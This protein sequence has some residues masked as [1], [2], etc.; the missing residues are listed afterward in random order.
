MMKRVIS[1][2]EF[3]SAHSGTNLKYMLEMSFVQGLWRFEDDGL[4]LGNWIGFTNLSKTFE[5][6]LSL[7]TRVQQNE[8][9]QLTIKKN[10]LDASSDGSLFFWENDVVNFMMSSDS[11][12][13]QNRRGRK[14]DPWNSIIAGA[15]IMLNKFMTAQPEPVIMFEDDPQAN[16][17]GFSNSASEMDNEGSGSPDWF[18][19]LGLVSGFWGCIVGLIAG[20]MLK[21][22]MTAQPEPVIMFED[23]PQANQAGFSNSA[24]EMDNEGLGSSGW[25]GVLDLVRRKRKSR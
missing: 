23:D 6:W 7:L 2:E 19:V 22:F 8:A 21:K 3:S 11:D 14:E 16:Q 24:S 13:E 10:A 1:F 20:I 17:A 5:E 25:F 18:G 9:T 15:G 12:D 4:Q